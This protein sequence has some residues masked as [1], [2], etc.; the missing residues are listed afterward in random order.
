MFGLVVQ[1]QGAKRPCQGIAPLVIHIHIRQSETRPFRQ[2]EPPDDTVSQRRVTPLQER[3]NGIDSCDITRL[4]RHKRL[5]RRRVFA[6]RQA[7]NMIGN[8]SKLGAREQAQHPRQV[9]AGAF[10]FWLGGLV[11]LEQ[12]LQLPKRRS[13]IGVIDMAHKLDL[14]A[15]QATMAYVGS[16]PW[17]GLSEQLL[18]E[19]D[20]DVAA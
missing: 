15:G 10:A 8:V 14:V 17:H 9:Q 16:V 1:A 19:A 5:D 7:L 20:G 11:R 3:N 4:L 18:P 6:R 13:Q 12:R 2:E